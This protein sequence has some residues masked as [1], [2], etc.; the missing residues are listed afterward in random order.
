MNGIE[1]IRASLAGT[2]HLLKWFVDDFSDADLL[3]RPV[4]NAN[5]AAWQI[6][7]VIGGDIYLVKDQ[8]PETSFPDLPEGFLEKHG[9]DGAKDDGPDGFLTKAEYVAL[10]DKVR[11]ATIAALDSLTDADLDR[12]TSGKMAEFAPTVGRLFLAVSDHTMMHAG[13][14]SVIRR[15]LG[16]PVLF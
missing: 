5:H 1:V 13:Q 11:A 8:F 3:A 6:G 12:P 4:P 2:Q 7:N 9:H 10:F 16:K 15:L 14:F